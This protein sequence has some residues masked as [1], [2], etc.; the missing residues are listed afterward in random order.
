MQDISNVV[1]PVS[2]AEARL[3]ADVCPLRLPAW[4][5]G[6]RHLGAPRFWCCVTHSEFPQVF[7]PDADGAGRQKVCRRR[8][9]PA[10]SRL[11]IVGLHEHKSTHEKK[12]KCVGGKHRAGILKGKVLSGS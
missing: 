4:G 8:A 9:S 6:P 7:I 2:S 5:A 10:Q 12:K 1:L 3:S 11:S